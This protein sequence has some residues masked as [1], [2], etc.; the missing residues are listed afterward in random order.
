VFIITALW[1]AKDAYIELA[2]MLVLELFPI[3]IFE[4]L[5]GT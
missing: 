2:L 3:I 5:C 1:F 4:A